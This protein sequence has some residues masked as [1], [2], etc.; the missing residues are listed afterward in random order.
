MSSTEE[1]KSNL[2]ELKK[3]REAAKLKRDARNKNSPSNSQNKTPPAKPRTARDRTTARSSAL[4]GD[5]KARTNRQSSRFG[6]PNTKKNVADKL[7]KNVTNTNEFGEDV[8]SDDSDEENKVNDEETSIGSE[9]AEAKA[10]KALA[11][12][13]RGLIQPPSINQLFFQGASTTQ[14]APDNTV[15]LSKNITEGLNIIK[16]Q[17]NKL[18]EIIQQG[19]YLQQANN[20]SNH[21]N[22]LHR[23]LRLEARLHHEIL[24]DHERNEG[25]V[26]TST[27]KDSKKDL[28]TKNENSSG[29]ERMKRYEKITKKK[30]ESAMLYNFVLNFV[31]NFV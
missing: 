13:T 19:F 9:N 21:P 25:F 30:K 5:K 4:G 6:K 31:L 22:V 23:N 24:E 29:S 15:Q 7:N 3:K 20:K 27:N 2:D 26:T 12:H 28:K 1:R 11:N 18:N 16:G 8:S 10:A 14:D 17:K